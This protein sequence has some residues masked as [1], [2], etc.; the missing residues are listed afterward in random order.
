[1]NFDIV[2]L[3][4]SKDYNKLPYLI[5]SIRNNVLGFKDVHIISPNKIVDRI[6]GIHYHTDKEALPLNEETNKLWNEWVEN[7]SFTRQKP[8][9]ILQQFIKLFNVV[10]ENDYLI[11]DS[12]IIFNKEIKIIENEKPNLFLGRNQYNREYFTFMEG[13]LSLE[14]MNNWS[15]ICELMFFKK[16][17]INKLLNEHFNGDYNSFIKQSIP[18]INDSCFISE[19][20]LY[21]NY[22][23]KNHS[24][25]Y[26]LK[27]I[28]CSLDGKHSEWN[29]ED[30]L[31][32]IEHYNNLEYDII[33][34]HSWL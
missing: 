25:E 30:I 33:T 23:M 9:W 20:E 15:F 6:E 16:N 34:I 8:N 3:S 24:N 12:D 21:G 32:R 5:E 19:F 14:K 17:I 29:N 18:L 1:M 31:E 28:N 2:I 7:N 26:N 4:H 13:I 11:V 10:T 22:V 27:K